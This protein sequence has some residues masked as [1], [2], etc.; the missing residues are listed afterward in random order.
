M[1]SHPGWP[2]ACQFDF[3]QKV[4][5]T[6]D[7][8]DVLSVRLGLV[9]KVALGHDPVCSLACFPFAAFLG[10]PDMSA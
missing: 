5:K 1:R 2:S 8:L 3:A 9:L 4:A 10:W 7:V 6:H